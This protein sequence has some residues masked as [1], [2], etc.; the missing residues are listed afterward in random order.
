MKRLFAL[1]A[2]LALLALPLASSA[3]AET[4]VK[5][6]GHHGVVVKHRPGHP[7]RVVVRPPA[8]RPGQFWHRGKWSAR[9]HGPAFRY[10]RGWH[11]RRWAV[12]AVLPALF[13]TANYFY[14]DYAP[15]GLQAPPP[16]YRWVRYGSDLLLVNV[17]TGEVEDTV[18][19]VFD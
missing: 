7:N 3:T 10:P 6:K 13:L 19:D 18:Y 14:D 11:Y 16:G 12:G 9:I 4:I 8:K 15:L 1:S 17:R 5:K 2:T